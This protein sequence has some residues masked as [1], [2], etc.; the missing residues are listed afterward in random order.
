MMHIVIIVYHVS[1]VMRKNSDNDDKVK[2]INKWRE[3]TFR[4]K[5][6]LFTMG[7]T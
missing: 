5:A 6:S 2:F 4:R 1:E 7:A 3:D